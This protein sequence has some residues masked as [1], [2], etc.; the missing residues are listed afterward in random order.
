[1]LETIQTNTLLNLSTVHLKEK[2]YK[3]SIELSQQVNNFKE[4]NMD[5]IYSIYYVIKLIQINQSVSNNFL[6]TK[7]LL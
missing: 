7:Y 1:M 3:I 6:A 2:N 4:L 5:Y